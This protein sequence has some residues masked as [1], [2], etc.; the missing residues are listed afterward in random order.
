MPFMFLGSLTDFFAP[1][2]I[3]MIITAM[4]EKDWEKVDTY[5]WKWLTIIIASTISSFIRDFV[6]AIA[7]ERLGMSL[8]QK[9]YDNVI[10]KDISFFDD[11][12]TGDILSRIGSDT[13]V[14]SD[15]LTT[16]VAQT[17]RAVTILT[18]YLVIMFKYS[19]ILTLILIAA[20]LPNVLA[21]RISL[22]ANR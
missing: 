4:G 13:Q 18:G 16:S 14:V 19:W 12:R 5:L 17:F 10:R 20:M 7:S 2:F 21:T 22:E 11:N 1:N 9:L 3:G 6:F 8:R 15:G